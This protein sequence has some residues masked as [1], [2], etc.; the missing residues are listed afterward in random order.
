MKLGHWV[1]GSF[2]HAFME[3]GKKIT[4]GAQNAFME[5]SDKFCPA[6]CVSK[7]YWVNICSV[8]AHIRLD[9]IPFQGRISPDGNFSP[10]NLFWDIFDKYE[11]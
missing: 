4:K 1:V 11:V 10:Q 9:I 2:L 7:L 6:K 3:T 5:S 8:G